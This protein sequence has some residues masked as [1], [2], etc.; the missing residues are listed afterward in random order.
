MS[1]YH[2]VQIG[3]L[4]LPGNLFLAPVAGY[5]DRAFR[6]ICAECGADFAYTE[7]VSSEALTRNNEKTE[8]LMRRAPNESAYAVQIFGGNPETMAQ[9]ARIVLEKTSCECIDINGGCPVPKIIKSNAGSALTRDPEHL[10]KIV[11]AVVES[12]KNYDGKR[13]NRANEIVPYNTQVP[14]TVK[15]RLGWDSESITWKECAEAA[16]KAGASAVTMHGRT[17][18]QGYEG[19]SDWNAL[20][21]LVKFVAELCADSQKIPVFGSGDAFTPEDA[22]RMLEETGVDAVMFARGAMGNPFLFTKTHEFLTNGTITELPVEKRIQ[23]GFRELDLL[24]QDLGELS[25]C[26]EAR[27]RFCAYSKGLEGG[28]ALRKEIVSAESAADYRAIFSQYL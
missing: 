14:V 25:A 18:A 5:S 4:S 13:L 8:T 6:S 15:F 19:K 22:K 12:V 2:P 7:M 16:I 11:S 10:F 24:I 9:A 17:R 3:N 21:E 23:A 20:A 27:K 28:A 1:L 26:R